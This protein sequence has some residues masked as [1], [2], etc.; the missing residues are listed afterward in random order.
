MSQDSLALRVMPIIAV[1][2]F[3]MPA[4]LSYYDEY[5]IG[6]AISGAASVL[7]SAAWLKAAARHAFDEEDIY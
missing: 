4:V 1:G 7:S 3:G 5:M 6:A 2:L